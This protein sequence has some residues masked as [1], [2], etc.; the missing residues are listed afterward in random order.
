MTEAYQS[1]ASGHEAERRAGQSGGLTR[2]QERG[3]C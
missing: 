3:R 2:G 1:E